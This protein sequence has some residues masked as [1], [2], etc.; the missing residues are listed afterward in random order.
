M[1]FH[2]LIKQKFK[3]NEINKIKDYFHSEIQERKVMSKKLINILL[4]LIILKRL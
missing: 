2:Y 4:F 1:Q 3:L